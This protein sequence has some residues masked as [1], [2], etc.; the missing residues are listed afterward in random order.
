[1]LPSGTMT[2]GAE[3]V[4][5]TSGG[6]HAVVHPF[7]VSDTG[8]HYVFEINAVASMQ[9]PSSSTGVLTAVA[10]AI[11]IGQGT[12][13]NEGVEVLMHVT[14]DANGNPTAQ[15]DRMSVRCQG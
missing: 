10:S 6:D 5:D 9:L 14:E 4:F 15:V 8:S 2:T 13:I 12:V 7:G 11:L 3:A 1:M